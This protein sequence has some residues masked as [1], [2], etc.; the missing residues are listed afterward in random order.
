MKQSDYII[1]T[2]TGK[3]DKI[4]FIQRSSGNQVKRL[5]QIWQKIFEPEALKM[6]SGRYSGLALRIPDEF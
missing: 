4:I 1:S 3:V 2:P 6:I 5:P